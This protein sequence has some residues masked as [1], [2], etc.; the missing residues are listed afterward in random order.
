MHNGKRYSHIIDPL[1]GYGVTEGKNVTVIANDAVTADWLATACSVLP[2]PKAK[3]LATR[4]R[5]GLL[6]AYLDEDKV[7]TETNKLF[8]KYWQ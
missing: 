8:L 1:T 5:A 7:K 4:M 2:V 6:I 3:R